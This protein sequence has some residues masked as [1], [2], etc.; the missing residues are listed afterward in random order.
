MRHKQ[1]VVLIALLAII[2][3]LTGSVARTAPGSPLVGVLAPVVVPALMTLYIILLLAN[4][5]WI[6]EA[7]AAFLRSRPKK[8]GDQTNFLTAILAYAIVIVLAV[9]L[10]RSGLIQRAVIFFQ[11]SASSLS[12]TGS[13]STGAGRPFPGEWF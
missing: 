11:Q 7:F 2:L 6:V 4:S 10:L 5:K 12:R 13:Q 3:A 1:I 8:E 9:L